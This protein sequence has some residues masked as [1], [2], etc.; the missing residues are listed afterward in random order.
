M[1]DFTF[2]HREE[3][4]DN[5]IDKS[6][7]GYKELLNDVVS[8]SRYFVEEKRRKKRLRRATLPQLMLQYPRRKQA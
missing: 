7:R 4:F 6:I 8:F 1:N 3:G 5:H 2:A